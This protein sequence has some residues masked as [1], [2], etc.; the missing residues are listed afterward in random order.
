MESSAWTTVV[1]LSL[2]IGTIATLANFLPALA[3]AYVFS[4]KDFSGKTFLE[5]VTNLPLVL[6]PVTTGYLLLMTFGRQGWLGKPLYQLTGYSVAFTEA[7]AVLACMI[8]SLP[9]MVRSMKVSLDMVDPRLE[10]V[11]QTLGKSPLQ[12][13]L[14]VSVPLMLPGLIN[15]TVLAFARS[16]GEFGATITFAGN[17]EGVS[18]TIPLAVYSLIQVPGRE[19]EAAILV[20]ISIVVSLGAMFI[21]SGIEDR[22]KAKKQRN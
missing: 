13:F 6:P 18:K 1:W 7:A 8:V 9:L 14:Q 22:L 20:G 16:L 21:S 12:T 15:G 3:L 17:I 4:R 5:G 11:A 2:K 10:Q 19:R